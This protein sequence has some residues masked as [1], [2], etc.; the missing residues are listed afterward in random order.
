MAAGL[1]EATSSDVG[2]HLNAGVVVAAI[3][4]TLVAALLA[5]AA[6]TSKTLKRQAV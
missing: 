1:S 2:L 3:I 4:G 5:G 6:V